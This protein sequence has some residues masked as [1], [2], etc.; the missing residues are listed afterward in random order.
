MSFKTGEEECVPFKSSSF[1]IFVTKIEPACVKRLQN[2]LVGLICNYIDWQDNM[3]E[4][5]GNR[6]FSS[7]PQNLWN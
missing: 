1:M 4:V 5:P 6:F 3:E 7:G 2:S